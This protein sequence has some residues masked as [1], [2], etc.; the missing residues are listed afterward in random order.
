M[1]GKTIKKIYAI[2]GPG[3]S[4]SAGI[5]V[6]ELKS[7]I[8][9][10]LTLMN[11]MNDPVSYQDAVNKIIKSLEGKRPNETH[12][13]LA[14]HKIPIIT[15]NVDML[16]QRAGSP[17]VAELH[18]NAYQGL[19]PYGEPARDWDKA[20]DLINSGNAHDILLVI[21]MSMHASIIDDLIVAAI[22]RNM[23]VIEIKKNITNK[24]KK[25]IERNK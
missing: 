11:K 14:K 22:S 25:V 3:L 8:R 19:V 21:G 4:R 7:D 15:L 2:T 24:I 17:Y 10:K 9:Q 18:G 20:A 5:P 6:L 13:L 23:H 12:L 16:H 1:E